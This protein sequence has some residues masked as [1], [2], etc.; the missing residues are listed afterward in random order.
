M[1]ASFLPY[2]HNFLEQ[3]RSGPAFYTNNGPDQ[4]LDRRWLVQQ[5]GAA[6][7][8]GIDLTLGRSKGLTCQSCASYAPTAVQDVVHSKVL[9]VPAGS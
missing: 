4:L 5:L 8:V 2:L 7:G 9:G 6:L 1:A 3:A